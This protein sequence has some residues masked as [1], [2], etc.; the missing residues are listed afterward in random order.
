[1]PSRLADD[2][3]LRGTRR[4]AARAGRGIFMLTKGGHTEIGFLE[5]LAAAS[6]RPVVIAALLHNS[7]NPDGVFQ[8]LE[9]IRSANG[10]DES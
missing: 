8:D 6:G 1:M 3:E 9:S 5:E 10:A 7:T 2:A 4:L